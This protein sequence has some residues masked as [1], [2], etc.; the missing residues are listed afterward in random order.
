MMH[1]IRHCTNAM[2]CAGGPSVTYTTTNTSRVHHGHIMQASALCPVSRPV[3][4]C[5]T[6]PSGSEVT[7]EAT[8]RWMLLAEATQGA[9]PCRIQQQVLGQG[10][11]PATVPC[12]KSSQKSQCGWC[13]C[14]R[15]D[16]WEVRD[17]RNFRLCRTYVDAGM[18]S[19]MFKPWVPGL[20][21]H[22]ALCLYCSQCCSTRYTAVRAWRY[23]LPGKEQGSQTPCSGAGKAHS[24]GVAGVGI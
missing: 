24:P 9:T 3:I 7:G 14:L 19:V 8:N 11:P 2:T 22:V 17:I 10:H 16:F 12:R 4:F 6:G 23:R 1:A 13:L 18:Q 20:C 15:V 21:W 5:H